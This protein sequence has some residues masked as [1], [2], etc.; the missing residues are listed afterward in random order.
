MDG[1]RLMKKNLL[2]LGFSFIL[3]ILFFSGCQEQKAIETSYLKGFEFK[4]ELVKLI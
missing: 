1:K 2:V 3:I 4:S